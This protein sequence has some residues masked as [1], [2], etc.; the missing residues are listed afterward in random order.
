MYCHV[1]R[2]PWL[3][4]TG[5]GLDDW[6]YWHFSYNHLWSRSIQQLTISDCLRLPPFCF[7]NEF[8]MTNHLRM[9]SFLVLLSTATPHIQLNYWTESLSLMLGPTVSR[10]V[11]LGI[12]HPSGAYDQIIITLRQLRVCWC[13]AFSLTRGRVCR[14]QL[15]LSLASA[16][17][18]ESESRGTRDHILLS[19]IRDF[20]FRRLLRPAELRWRYSTPPPHGILTELRVLTCSPFI[21]SEGPNRDHH[22]Q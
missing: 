7:T 14:L 13:G 17:I 3:I 8:R 18:L 21:T 6:I 15:L 19:Q 5:S 4:I 12:K 16:V 22:L 20:T 1:S 2:V 10:S 11:C 9:I